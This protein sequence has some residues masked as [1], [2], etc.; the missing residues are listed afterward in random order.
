MKFDRI[1]KRI[2][3]VL[4]H[5][6]RE[7]LSNI[8]ERLINSKLGAMSHTGIRKRIRKL[9]DAK[10]IKL[11]GNLNFKRLKYQSVFIL[12]EMKN[13]VEVKK[14]INAYSECPRVF[15]LATI[16][17]RYN[18]IMGVIG[19]NS[20]VLQN[21]INFCGPSNKE[22]VLH[23]EV[24]NVSSLETP[25]FLPIN[26]FSYESQENKCGNICEKCEALLNGKCEGCG[27]F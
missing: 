22:G 5:N 17:G 3:N 11:Q 23:S 20:E 25:Q 21:Y 26:I 18:L 10:V 19:Q 14:M 24:L 27:H 8:A 12:M 13:Y 9:M 4:F 6:G 1:D 15:L 7:T 2:I 16:A